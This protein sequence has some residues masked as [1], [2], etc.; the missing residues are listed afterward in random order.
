VA[1]V[2]VLTVDE[3]LIFVELSERRA[4]GELGSIS[5]QTPRLWGEKARHATNTALCNISDKLAITLV[6]SGIAFSTGIAPM[7]T[8]DY[9]MLALWTGD[10]D[11]CY[12]AKDHIRK[13]H[14][15]FKLPLDCCAGGRKTRRSDKNT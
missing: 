7:P 3:A 8:H 11:G 14:R 4:P 9:D 12:H 15:Y 13:P 1:D 5:Q 2:L 6:C 10:A